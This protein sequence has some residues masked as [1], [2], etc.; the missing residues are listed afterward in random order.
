MIALVGPRLRL[1][2]LILLIVLAIG[3]PLVLAIDEVVDDYSTSDLVSYNNGVIRNAT[4]EVME[5]NLTA[6]GG[7]HVNETLTDYT[8]V[9]TNN[10]IDVSSDRIEFVNLRRDDEAYV[11]FDYG[12]DYWDDF[13]IEFTVVVNDTEAGDGDQRWINFIFSLNN[14]VGAF[15]SRPPGHDSLFISIRDNGATDNSYKFS[16]SGYENAILIGEDIGKIRAVSNTPLYLRVN[17]TDDDYYLWVYSDSTYSTLD[18]SLSLLNMGLTEPLRYIYPLQSLD[19]GND[20]NIWMSGY[21][22][23]LWLGNTSRAFS[24]AGHFNTTNY[25]AGLSYNATVLLTDTSIPSGSINAEISPD[26]ST[27]TDLGNLTTGYGALDL[28]ALG[29]TDAIMRFNF[30][31]GLSTETPRL[32]QVRLIYEGPGAGVGNVTLQN[33]TGAWVLHN[34]SSILTLRGTLDSGD[35]NSTLD[36]DGDSYTVSEVVGAPGFLISFNWTAVDL[37]AH[38]LWIVINALYD[39]NL[40]HDVD[41]ELYNH[42]ALAWVDIG[43]IL[44]GVALEWFNVSVYGLRIPLDFLNGAGD[45]WGRLNHVSAGNINHDLFIEYL[46]L[47]AFIPSDVVPTVARATVVDVTPFIAIGLILALSMYLLADR[48]RK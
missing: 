46:K 27:W 39:G 19:V 15:N 38:C 9:D 25:L 14:F 11:Y 1:S 48:L 20:G 24:P 35:L 43:H 32:A 3:A 44:D 26:G 41:I 4:L 30:T 40:A 10:K 16:L 29:L 6:S 21:V 31:R 28:R 13:Q 7:V 12:V 22:K 8:T 37:D 17:R 33:V 18:E 5:L 45:V 47:H 23:D 34:L 42:T 36:I 2:F